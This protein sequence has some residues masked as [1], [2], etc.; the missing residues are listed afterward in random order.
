MSSIVAINARNQ[1]KER[2]KEITP[3]P[4]VSELLSVDEAF[5]GWERANKIHFG[6]GGVFDQVYSFGH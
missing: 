3:G 1:L 2:I 6:D 4:V 5:G